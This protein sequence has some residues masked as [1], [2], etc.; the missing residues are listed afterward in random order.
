MV[1]RDVDHQGLLGRVLSARYRL[2]RLLGAGGMGA[3]FAAVDLEHD[4][5]CAIKVIDLSGRPDALRRFGREAALTFGHDHPNVVPVID[6]GYDGDLDRP[7]L[8]MPR[9]EGRDL[10]ARLA[11][12]GAVRA[13]TAARIARQAALGL[14]A[15]HAQGIVHRDVKPSNLFLE[16][17]TSEAVVR[18]M[19][20]GISKASMEL[21]ALTATGTGLGTPSYMAPE[22]IRD[23]KSASAR[24]D[25]YSLGVVLYEMLSGRLPWT[26]T[27]SLHDL[28]Q[29]IVSSPPLSLAGIAPSVHPD[30]A[31]VAMRAL[32]KNPDLR[33]ADAESFA[34]ALVPFCGESDRIEWAEI[35]IT[36][37]ELWPTGADSARDHAF[38][39]TQPM[40]SPT[41]REALLAA[42]VTRPALDETDVPRTV[43][44][45]ISG[46]IAA[47]LGDT[48]SGDADARYEL[49]PVV[50]KGGMGV[51]Y[52]ARD[53]VLGRTV[54]LKIL[55]DDDERSGDRFFREALAQA[56]VEHENVCRVFEVG[57]LGGK[58]FIAM[59]YIEGETLQRA[60]AAMT[61]EAKALV[62]MQVAEALHA[63]HRVGLIHRD[64]KPSNVLVETDELG[65]AKPYIVDFGIARQTSDEGLTLTGQVIG[66]PQYMAPEQAKGRAHE[67][68]RR[69]D[70]Y[71]LGATLYE[72]LVGA[73]PFVGTE[74]AELILKI[75]TEEPIPPRQRDPKIP[76]DLETI[77]LSCL[78][79]EPYRRYESARAL[80][81]DLQRWLDGQPILARTTGRM[82]RLRMW[83]RRHVAVSVASAISILAVGSVAAF[84]HVKARRDLDTTV[85]RSVAV[86]D[87]ALREAHRAA[88]AE[89]SLEQRAYQLFDT[90]AADAESVWDQAMKLAPHVES[91]EAAASEALETALALDPDR[92]DVRARLGD[93]LLDRALRADDARQPLLRDALVQ[94]LFRCCDR[95]G[96]RRRRWEAGGTIDIDV[97][98][99]GATVT[100]SHIAPDA[101]GRM[102]EEPT[103]PM[104]RAPLMGFSLPRGSYV[105]AFAADGR[106]P[107]RF[108]VL[109]HRG[110]SVRIS[111]ELPPTGDVPADYVYVPPGRFVTGSRY[112]ELRPFLETTPC[113]DAATGGYL[114]ARHE[115]TIG[116]WMA[117]LDAATEQERA[118][119]SPRAAGSLVGSVRLERV[120]Q[121]WHYHLGSDST[122]EWHAIPGEKL[123]YK[124]RTQRAEQDWLRFPVTGI[125][126]DDAEAYVAWLDRAG[127]V[128]GARLCTGAEWE[129]AARGADER[130]FPHGDVLEPDEANFYPTQAI[131]GW[132][133]DE[134]GSHPLSRSVF[135][136][137][138]MAGNAHEL[139]TQSGRY[140]A[141]GGSYVETKTTQL[142]TNHNT[143]ERTFRM[144]NHG[145]RVCVTYPRSK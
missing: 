102:V 67:I 27:T 17:R 8:V 104:G 133:P 22:Q 115:T 11:R 128:P 20:F 88:E 92:S 26:H 99:A 46:G 34:A 72:L 43:G 80:A 64:V 63:A 132:G 127:R 117:F 82:E 18:L 55:R 140:V 108:P 81:E 137:D 50:G 86:A 5:P 4:A 93:V 123:H 52:K 143:V 24:A 111:F 7:F 131:V 134:V 44:A 49:G 25:V 38:G 28:L 97:R 39:A 73:P 61:L 144:P 103:K 31:A 78:A 32:D 84:M 120:D 37:S 85:Q 48:P 83:A 68:D 79:K 36:V 15:V 40:P 121:T 2:D 12:G 119:H 145:L 33:F 130:E 113:H 62:L 126:P 125:S 29:Q 9:L 35:T 110:E 19:D 60:A 87:D 129:R 142:I 116:E 107:V 109:V 124:T 138:D 45:P 98:P 105:L 51:V 1:V 13:D 47:R 77:T 112:N 14:M 58:P 106:A 65:R 139:T 118:A 56:K 94:R 135:G 53:K 114:I 74:P 66:T 54:A 6:A 10:G 70:V 100:L 59:Q 23:A 16:R 71:G 42:A 76:V 21:E 122:H 57:T 89:I 141:R 96:S 75:L 30:L 91:P 41:E 136:L 3:V 95:D 90:G 69:T 101:A